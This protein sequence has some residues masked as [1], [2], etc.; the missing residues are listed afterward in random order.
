MWGIFLFIYLLKSCQKGIERI[1]PIFDNFSYLNALPLHQTIKM[2][3]CRQ[4]EEL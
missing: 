3:Q 2:L 1:M 4:L